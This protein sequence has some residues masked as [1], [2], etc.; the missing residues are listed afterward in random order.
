MNLAKAIAEVIAAEGI[1]STRPLVVIQD[2]SFV[3]PQ[4]PL[5][6][7]PPGSRLIVKDLTGRRDDYSSTAGAASRPASK[8]DIA[9]VLVTSPGDEPETLPARE[10]G[11]NVYQFADLMNA[12]EIRGRA[13]IMTADADIF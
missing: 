2:G 12:R 4:L 11:L 7:L 9:D 13:A 8:A 6:P 3:G 10:E 5:P 1:G